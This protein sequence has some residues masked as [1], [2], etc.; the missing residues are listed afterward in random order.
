MFPNSEIQI[1]TKIGELDEDETPL[2]ITDYLDNIRNL[3]YQK[4]LEE[5][6]TWLQRFFSE[7]EEIKDF[8]K[9]DSSRELKDI[10][11]EGYENLGTIKMP[12]T[13]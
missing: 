5:R 4:P 1:G 10:K 9:I 7:H 8:Y 2:P 12:V 6:D 13:E 3:Y 11:L